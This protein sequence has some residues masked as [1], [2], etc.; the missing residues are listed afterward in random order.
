MPGFFSEC[1]VEQFTC[2]ILYLN[3]YDKDMWMHKLHI[4]APD[5]INALLS[6]FMRKFRTLTLS[7]H[8]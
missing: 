4:S 6:V 3:H 5:M 8:K 7:L 2:A 1:E